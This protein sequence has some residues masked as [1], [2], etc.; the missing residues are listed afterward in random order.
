[1]EASASML[2]LFIGIVT[3]MLFR[4]KKA[5]LYPLIGI[6][7]LGAGLLDGYHAL[8]S[9]PWFADLLLSGLPSLMSWS[10]LASRFFFVCLLVAQRSGLEERTEDAAAGEDQLALEVLGRRIFHLADC[11]YLGVLH[12][13]PEVLSGD[14]GIRAR[15]V[16]SRGLLFAGLY[17]L[18]AQGPL[19]RR[20][21]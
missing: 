4:G 5:D 19:E 6:G 2:A 21:F 11:S 16:D 17:R 7:F 1:M 9:A 18:C 13:A 8:L 3:L 15:G 12:H 20:H 10:G 14:H